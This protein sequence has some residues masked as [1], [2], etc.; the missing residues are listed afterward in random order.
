M[1]ETDPHFV[2][3]VTTRDVA[4]RA[5]VSTATVSLALRNN[6]RISAET[7]DR[8][9]RA[10]CELGYCPDPQIA[11]LMHHLRS[12]RPPGFQST[13][14]ALTTIPL[15]P[16]SDYANVVHRSAQSTAESLGYTF[17]VMLLRDQEAQ[18]AALQRILISRGVEGILL[19]PMAT[20][21]RVDKW[22][23]WTLFSVVATTYGV[24]APDVHRIVP[25][26]FGNALRICD[27]LAGLGYRRVGLVISEQHDLTAHFGFSA[28]I[29]RQNMFGST[30]SVR[31]LV[32]GGEFPRDLKRWFKEEQP[33]VIIASSE[34]ECRTFARHLKLKIPGPVGFAVT[35][36][37]GPAEIA[38]IHE[39]P[40]DIGAAAISLLHTKIMS[41]DLGVPNVPTLTMIPGEWMPGPSVRPVH[42]RF[43]NAKRVSTAPL[44]SCATSA[45]RSK[46]KRPP[47]AV[48]TG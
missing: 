7:R 11:K 31:P 46:P 24:V 9:K 23:N 16:G 18:A 5:G 48:A 42:Q 21:R 32:Y 10:A 40:H 43:K 29:S 13:I 39:R 27:E 45:N 19:L 25:H 2:R 36:R 26:H 12:K 8:V 44:V 15:G 6:P 47:R 17:M 41:G 1:S 14:A 37:Y 35:D 20:P 33:D 34:S 3:S 4:A 38:G 22:I 28:A 30:E